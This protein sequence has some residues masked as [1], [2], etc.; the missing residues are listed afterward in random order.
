MENPND[1]NRTLTF[2]ALL[3]TPYDQHDG[4]VLKSLVIKVVRDTPGFTNSRY[5]A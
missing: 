3:M 5:H 1:K 2:A 4:N